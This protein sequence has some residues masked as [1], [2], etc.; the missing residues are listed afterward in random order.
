[1]TVYSMPTE[2]YPARH[3][4]RVARDWTDDH[5][6]GYGRP[7]L[8]RVFGDLHAWVGAIALWKHEFAEA[9]DNYGLPEGSSGPT[10]PHSTG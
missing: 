9:V 2:R 6:V 3:A 10:S 5:G 1:M 7:G 4:E 8:A